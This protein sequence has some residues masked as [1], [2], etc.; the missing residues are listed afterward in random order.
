MPDKNNFPGFLFHEGTNYRAYEY[1]GSHDAV[2]A[3]G[4]ACTVFRVWA[5]HAKSVKVVGDFCSWQEDG[6]IPMQRIDGEG[7]IFE[8]YGYGFKDYD[9]YKYLVEGCDGRKVYKSDPYAVHMETRP[10]TGSKIYHLDGYK[11]HDHSWVEKREKANPYRSPI[12]IYEVHLGSWRLKDNSVVYDYVSIAKQLA[13]YVKEMGYTHVEVMPLMEYPYDGS[14]GYQVLD[15]FAPTSRYGTPK[16]LMQFVDIL[17]QNGIGVIMDWVPAHFPKD[18]SGLSSFDGGPTYEYADPRKGEHYEW[19]TK[20][21]DFGKP[22]VVSFLTSSALY[23]LGQYHF[24]GLRVDAV[25]SMLYLNYARRDGEWIPNKNGGIENL[26]AITFLQKLNTYVFKEY[27][28]TLMIAEESTAW[29]MV[30]KPVE[31]GGLGFNFKWNMGWMN[32]M[33][34]YVQMDPVYRKDHHNA[35]TFSLTYAFSENYILPLS[36]DEVVHGKKSL[37][38][39]QPG[40]YEQKFAGLRAFYGYMMGHPGKK[41]LFMGGEFA[42]FIEWDYHKQLDWF[43]LSY[44]M[45]QKMQN[46][47]KELNHFYLE[48]S[49]MYDNDDSWDGFKWICY[50]DNLQNIVSFRRIDHA[51]K[52]IVEVVNFAPVTRHEYRIGV[53]YEGYY[54]EVLNSDDERF[55][56]S[57]VKNDKWIKSEKIP[58]HGYDQSISITVPPLAAVFFSVRKKKK[59]SDSQL[60]ETKESE[61]PSK[62]GSTPAS[63][64]TPAEKGKKA[65]ADSSTGKK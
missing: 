26:E 32:D 5:P 50:D 57:G 9:T 63:L 56:G 51:G 29:P 53:P 36:H 19:G 38:D 1:F 22:E 31:D 4:K 37:I 17:H 12:N 43:L 18:E 48:H 33:L 55:G 46:Y 65:K 11:W 21:F 64:V 35:I 16:D 52:E 25:A 34:E 40:T 42:Q 23:W 27:P 2:D 20:V 61:T 10:A 8:A 41:L 30:T 49:Q 47:V 45:H 54:I 28:G 58:S 3:E 60:S 7:G 24:D 15:Y 13:E 6:A 39:K 44:N 59:A 14:W 62:D